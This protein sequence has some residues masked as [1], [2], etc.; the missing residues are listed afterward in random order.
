MD[1]ALELEVNARANACRFTEIVEDEGLLTSAGASTIVPAGRRLQLKPWLPSPAK[2]A[3]PSPAELA[4]PPSSVRAAAAVEPPAEDPFPANLVEHFDMMPI[5]ETMRI[6]VSNSAKKRS[7]NVLRFKDDFPD[8]LESL[9]RTPK[10]GGG[11]KVRPS[12][13]SV[14]E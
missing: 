13:F 7:I 9:F 1:F 5:G 11:A 6:G 2:E 12:L 14:H 8:D 4:T 10:K 3:Q